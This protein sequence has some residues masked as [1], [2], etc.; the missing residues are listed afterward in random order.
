MTRGGDKML[1]KKGHGL[2]SEP[3]DWKANSD[4]VQF[5]YLFLR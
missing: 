5:L 1:R 4:S 2:A 3:F